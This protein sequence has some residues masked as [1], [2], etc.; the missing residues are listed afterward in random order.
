MNN[1]E[2]RINI[3]ARIL[4]LLGPS[5]Y[6]NIYYVLAELIANAYDAEAHNVYV[7]DNIDTGDNITVEDDGS[8]MSYSDGDI[9]KYLNV[10]GISRTNEDN[11]ITPTLK[12]KKMGRK[13]VGKLAAL[14]VSE[15]VDVLTIHDGEKSGF[16]LTRDSKDGLLPAIPEDSIRLSRV[17]GNG[18]SIVMR[19]PKYK[20]SES[21]ITIK[22]NLLKIFP[23]VEEN[24][25]IHIIRGAKEEL[26][27]RVDKSFAKELCALITLGDS[28]KNLAQ[29][30]PNKYP[31]LRDVLVETRPPY[32][33][34]IK[35]KN[36]DNVERE[37]KLIIEGWLGTYESSRG[38]KLEIMDFPDNFIS[39][40]S[41][42]KM[43]E[44]NLLPLVGKNK[45]NESYVVGQ[46]HVDLLEETE[47][48]DIALSN[49]QGYKSDDPRYIAVLNYLRDTL[50]SDILTKR[51]KFTNKKNSD[52]EN[53]K[54]LRLKQL[55][56]DF[57]S[58][59]VSF[60]EKAA[61]EAVGNILKSIPE[62]AEK[63]VQ[64]ILNA[65]IETNIG[66]L[67]IKPMLDANKKRLLISHTRADKALADIIYK[68]LLFNNVPQN[69]IL[70]TSCDDSICRLPDSEEI[71][72][73]LRRFFVDSYSNQKIYVIFVTSEHTKESWGAQME[74]GA[75]WITQVDN[76]IF[77]IPPFR[78]ENPMDDEHAWHVTNRDV[79]THELS[80]TKLSCDT[81]YDKIETI[82][83]S[84]GYPKK[85]REENK[86]YLSTLVSVVDD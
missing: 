70:Y 39:L 24:F 45:M 21:L 42:K 53:R 86:E 46:L 48:P 55:E 22:K 14:S 8:G 63:D 15:K 18:T 38:R 56:S 25:R 17:Q 33:E 3:D 32:S 49:R 69:E 84:L 28:F 20:L 1:K 29:L 60:K 75:A 61:K 2:Y 72:D 82:C 6:T 65:A 76:R 37:Y 41:H 67:G 73:Y 36:N 27:D 23:L 68:M 16:I 12:R 80:M 62:A 64:N 11:S 43:G 35:M 47:L 77:N 44:F 19:K 10:A 13:G 52:R 40:Y 50:L 30:V 51:T 81:F 85:G 7:I 74:I 31:D 5:L 34:I 54:I 66:S 57:S 83:N 9:N 71:Y 78:P 4:D 79:H 26:L 58:A 59:V